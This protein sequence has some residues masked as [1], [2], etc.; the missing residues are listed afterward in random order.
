MLGTASYLSPEQ[1]QGERA[2]PASD[3][4]GLAV[5][6]FELL[7]GERPFKG[8]TAAAEAA[9][10]V[11]APV[12]A[13]SERRPDLPRELDDV[14]ARALAKRPEARHAS[15]AEFVAAVRDALHA[16]ES[17]TQVFVA[18]PAAPSRRTAWVLPAVIL[19]ALLGGGLV[20]AALLVADDEP[21][22]SGETIVRTVTQRG[23][24]RE[25]T[26]TAERE[27]VTVTTAP[28]PDP[29]P[30]AAGLTVA[31]ARALQDESTAAMNA[32]DWER[33]LALAQQALPALE[34][35]D[36]TYEGYASFNVGNSLAQLGRCDEALPYLDR[37]E[38]LGGPHPAVDRARRLCQ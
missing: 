13:I 35:R 6:A 1:A 21:Q 4:Y 38:Q 20:L 33:A 30:P 18:P 2:T 31:Q 15:A 5:V 26:V 10:H 11:S 22:A 25:V 7:A 29:A 34:G 14:F 16:G 37:R 36:P 23:E 3:R 27:P 24:T 12:P 19:L 17:R 9:A 8:D 28:E 32:S